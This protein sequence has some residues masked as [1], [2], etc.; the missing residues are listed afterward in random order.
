[1]TDIEYWNAEYKREVEQYTSLVDNLASVSES[2]N[3][4]LIVDAISPCEEKQRRLKDIKKSYGL[5]LRLVKDQ[6]AKI[7]YTAYGKT[8]DECVVALNTKLGELKARFEK[9]ALFQSTGK[10]NILNVE[11]KTNDQLLQGANILQDKTLESIGRTAQLIEHSKEVGT[12]TNET[13]LQQRQQMKDI[14]EEVDNI[15]SK[16]VRADKLILDFTRRMATDKIIQAFSALNI[17]VMLGLILY[18]AIS[19]RSLTA[20]GGSNYNSPTLNALPTTVPTSYPTFLPTMSFSPTVK[21]SFRPTVSHS[22]TSEP[23]VSPTLEPTL[24]YY[25]THLPTIYPT[26]EP[27]LT[28]R[29]TMLP[30]VPPSTTPSTQPTINPTASPTVT[31]IP[32]SVPTMSP[33]LFPTFAPTPEPSMIPSALPTTWPPTLAPS[34]S[35]LPTDTSAPSLIPSSP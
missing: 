28:I 29:P 1:M 2:F 34:V 17:V 7:Q 12:A 27:T 35:N 25:P 13:L 5:E 3:S 19:G 20:G 16:M 15:E 8:Y 4:K 18:V 33:S 21:P 31:M 9:R 22:P 24:T 14:E 10:D 30:T 6:I 23:T 26:V 32:T 11:G